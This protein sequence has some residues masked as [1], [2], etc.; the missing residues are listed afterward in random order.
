MSS[1]CFSDYVIVVWYSKIQPKGLEVGQIRVKRL[2][3][4]NE[5]FNGDMAKKQ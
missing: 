4:G 3:T 2:L 1:V 5:V